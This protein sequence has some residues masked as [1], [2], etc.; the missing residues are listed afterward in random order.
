[1]P[2]L[3]HVPAGYQAGAATATS[4]ASVQ[5]QSN[6]G[7]FKFTFD[8]IRPGLFRTTFTSPKHL[9]PPHRA[10]PVPNK[11]VDN[12]NAKVLSSGAAAKSFQVDGVTAQVD[13]ESGLP[14]VS[15]TL[16]GQQKPIHAD[17]PNRSYA[18]DGPGIAHYTKYNHGTLHLGLG[19]K[20]APMDLSNRHFVLS[21]TDSFGYD[22]YRTDPL[23]KHIPLL[24]NATPD[25]C[26]GI[27]STSHARG[28]YSVGSEMDGMWGRFK[29]YRQ[30]YGGLE[31]YL[32]VGKTLPDIVRIYADLVGYPLLVPRWAFGYLAGG[33]KYSMTDDPPASQSMM[34][35]ARKLKEHDIPCSGMQMS[36]G[37]TVA[38]TEPKTRN[39]F[40]WNRHRF[41][42]P[43]GWIDAYHKEGI[44]LIANVKPYV[45]GSH[46]EYQ[47]LRAANAFFTDSLTT[48]PAEARLWSA[49]GGESGIG[50]HIDFTSKAGYQW[51]YE[52]IRELKRIG[53]DCIWNDNNEYTIPHDGWQCEL[54]E[55]SVSQEPKNENYGQEI[56][57]WGR[58]LN[59]ELM[60]KSSHDA[61]LEVEP[62]QRPFILTRSA[63]AGT[64]RYCASAW[65]GDNVTSWPGMKGANAL[66]LTA[67]ICLMQ[68]Y[69]HDIGGFEGPQPSPELLVRW[70][71]QG[72]YSP[73]FAIN[74]F[75]TGN[76]NSV[77]D[78]IEPWMYP[79][80]TV[81]VRDIIK[82]RYEMIPYL[83]SLALHSHMTA[84]P[85]QRW[86][87]WGYESDPEIWNN[88]VLTDGETQYW[89]GDA[90][91]VGGVFEANAESAKMYLPKDASDPNAEFL[92]LNNEPQTY[93]KAGQWVD[94]QAKWTESIP[95]LA[96]V[97]SAIPVGRAEQVLSVGEKSNP[98]NLA[99]DDYRAVEVFPPKA[100]LNG[101]VYTT[102]WYEDDGV[103]PPPA[104]ISVFVVKY[105]ASESE[106]SVSYEEKLQEGFEPA[107]SS[108]EII[109][110]RGDS[111]SVSFNGNKA[112]KVD[113]DA[114]GRTRWKGVV[115]R[116]GK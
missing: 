7:D 112:E 72:I 82:R 53:I 13:W 110:P 43:K 92:D 62:E 5:L 3:E 15:L 57:F 41:P 86:A 84:T 27:F 59:T 71:Q 51:W 109:L 36:S 83:Y 100:S 1:M 75:K 22:V 35:F 76:D 6:V 93:Y 99:R 63:T 52:G 104:K 26:V 47:K 111:R 16:S 44:R 58:A 48:A 11:T 69:G 23:Y 14:L 108:L 106:V 42:D 87:G 9:L 113:T 70:C 55:P 64:L 38:E 29:V 66:S 61:S 24:I 46:P 78:V 10:V 65:S 103:S 73:R 115:E 54:S 40:T 19:E 30:D 105:E 28:F 2:M 81:L 68:C 37:Y 107:W 77:G 4:N 31:E 60:G 20:P 50:G 79:E 98:A 116:S 80:T 90:L 39:V 21:A 18:A 96:K 49:G 34:E 97:G 85:P 56:G 45:L 8:V 67:G 88:R 33:M 32:L 94:I 89:L 74:C 102:T 91:L 101:K 114:K 25:G 17:L 95:V 12:S